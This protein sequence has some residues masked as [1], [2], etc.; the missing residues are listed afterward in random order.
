MSDRS[1]SPPAAP[2]AVKAD[3]AEAQTR[4]LS[5]WRQSRRVL[6]RDAGE[7]PSPCVGVCQMSPHTGL[8]MGC[9]RSLDEIGHW[10]SAPQTYKRSVW[11]RIQQRLHEAYPQGLSV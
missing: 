4:D 3:P 9:W 1:P 7:C 6:Q 8:C 2:A 5:L 11:Q 10:G